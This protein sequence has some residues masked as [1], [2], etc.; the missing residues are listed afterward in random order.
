M[1]RNIPSGGKKFCTLIVP[2][3]RLLNGAF[4]NKKRMLI[5]SKIILRN[6]ELYIEDIVFSDEGITFGRGC[7]A[8]DKKNRNREKLYLKKLSSL[9]LLTKGVVLPVE[10]AVLPSFLKFRKIIFLGL[11]GKNMILLSLRT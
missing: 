6:F 10:G 2:P 4:T 5:F 3:N 8:F 9:F 7:N 1:T 11:T